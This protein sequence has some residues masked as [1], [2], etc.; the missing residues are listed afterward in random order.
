AARVAVRSEHARSLARHALALALSSADLPRLPRPDRHHS[1]LAVAQ[2]P[3]PRPRPHRRSP[4]RHPVLVR[5]SG[6]RVC[7]VVS[8]SLAPPRLPPQFVGLPAAPPRRRLAAAHRPQ[9]GAL[10]A[11]LP[12][13]LLPGSSASSGFASLAVSASHTPTSLAK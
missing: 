6:R 5:R 8:A 2:G 11:A 13:P 7:L 12:P 9:A 10:R 1:V 4:A 3:R